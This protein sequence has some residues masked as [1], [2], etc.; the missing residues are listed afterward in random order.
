MKERIIGVNE[1]HLKSLFEFLSKRRQRFD[2]FTIVLE[3]CGRVPDVY[4]R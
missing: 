1:E 2:S 4:V 3:E